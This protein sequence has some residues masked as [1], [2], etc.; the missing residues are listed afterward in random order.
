MTPAEQRLLARVR[1]DLSRLIRYDDQSVV[2]D[3]WIWQRYDGG[4]AVSL[5]P[6][7]AAAVRTAW[8]EAGHAVAALA[9]GARFSSASI[10][11]SAVSRDGRATEGRVHG[12]TGAGD[13]GFV[14]DAG[15]QVAERLMDWTMPDGDD[16]LR[17]WL[18]GW[19]A[20]GGDAGRFRRSIGARFGRDEA[21]AWRCAESLL[22]PRRLAIRTVARGL[23]VSPRH[24][25]F[26]VVA[27]IAADAHHPAGP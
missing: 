11:H 6:A 2:H 7:R 15:G 18:A 20:D 19:R 16:E 17:R 25:P 5:A 10:R 27:A 1:A 22:T 3:T 9:V 24:L 4:H 26:A 8:H 12:L 21:A 23:L 14:I 13:Q